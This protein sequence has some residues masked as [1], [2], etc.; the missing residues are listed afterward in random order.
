MGIEVFYCPYCDSETR[1]LNGVCEACKNAVPPIPV[2]D[3]LPS[4]DLTFL[5]IL[6]RWGVATFWQLLSVICMWGAIVGLLFAGT[7]VFVNSGMT[8]IA[9]KALILSA[10]AA[11]G[12]ALNYYAEKRRRRPRFGDDFWRQL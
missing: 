3:R 2:L 7:V 4:R 6:W 12:A 8:P 9:M 11:F 10:I 5:Q 1:T